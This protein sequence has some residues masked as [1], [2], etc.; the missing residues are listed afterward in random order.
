MAGKIRYNICKAASPV[1]D[2]LQGSH[3]WRFLNQNLKISGISLCQPDLCLSG[4]RHLGGL[5]MWS[6]TSCWPLGVPS[7]NIRTMFQTLLFHPEAT[8]KA[9]KAFC[10]LWLEPCGRDSRPAPSVWKGGFS[11]GQPFPP[12]CW[13]LQPLSPFL[14]VE[15]EGSAGDQEPEA[16]LP[17]TSFCVFFAKL[18]SPRVLSTREGLNLHCN[19]DVVV[20]N[21]QSRS[22]RSMSH[23]PQVPTPCRS[24]KKNQK[25]PFAFSYLMRSN[26][27]KEWK[28]Q[29]QPSF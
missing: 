12:L 4:P 9:C 18:H 11:K 22:C 21:V 5:S 13:S 28:A 3:R 7:P 2:T 24:W 26:I 23:L 29:L 14:S 8:W 25:I 27:L 20:F 1:P 19:S 15:G 16:G 10:F 6:L 17:R